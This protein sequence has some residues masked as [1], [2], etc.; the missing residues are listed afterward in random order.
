M[1]AIKPMSPPTTFTEALVVG[2]RRQAS[3]LEATITLLRV[4]PVVTM[5]NSPSSSATQRVVPGCSNADRICSAM[6]P[7]RPA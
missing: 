7:V 3:E 6:P 4:R 2:G 1:P 5:P